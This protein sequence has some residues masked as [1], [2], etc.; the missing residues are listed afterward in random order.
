MIP[1]NAKLIIF[2]A[3]SGAGKTTVVRHLLET[4]NR[5]GFSVSATTRCRRDKE[6]D[7]RDYYFLTREEFEEKIQNNE[8]LEWEEVYDGLYYGTLI[9]EVERLT[10]SG[11]AVVFDID[12]K[13][14]LSIKKKYPGQSL[15]VFV[16][17]PSL[18][19]L[20]DRLEQRATE[21]HESLGFRMKRVQ[22]EMSFEK[23][24]DK[25]IINNALEHSLKRARQLVDDF[26][27]HS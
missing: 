8:F 13:G 6:V 23:A 1:G 18:E 7:K 24:F 21:T 2:T 14:A 9:S 17:P 12:V 10:K 25:V 15:S 4:D 22:Y 20:Q 27:S 19:I 5:L 11:K 3:P 16:K 26:L